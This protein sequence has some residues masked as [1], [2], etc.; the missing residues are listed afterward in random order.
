M[1]K[2]YHGVERS[3]EFLSLALFLETQ[4]VDY[5]GEVATKHMNSEDME[6]AKAMQEE[7]LI[8]FGRLPA[9]YVFGEERHLHMATYRVEFSEKMW[10]IAH[11]ERRERAARSV[12][13]SKQRTGEVE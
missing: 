8:T 12:P 11:N 1:R 5:G 6:I 4:L 9:D 2:D 13:K 7:G 3:E 10:E